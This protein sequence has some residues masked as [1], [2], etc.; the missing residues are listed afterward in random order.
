MVRQQRQHRDRPGLP[1]QVRLQRQHPGGPAGRVA[2]VA[3]CVVHEHQRHRKAIGFLAHPGQPTDRGNGEGRERAPERVAL[4]RASQV[5][6]IV[7]AGRRRTL[8]AARTLKLLVAKPGDFLLPA[9]RF[10]GAF[11][12]TFYIFLEI[13]VFFI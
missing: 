7:V 4:L 12:K 10:F 13:A 3:A 1:G 8:D 11:L 5:L 2:G 9:R 6:T